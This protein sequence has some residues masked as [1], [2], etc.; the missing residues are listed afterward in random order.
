MLLVVTETA[1]FLTEDSY[2]GNITDPLTL[3][4]YNY[5]KSSPLNYIDPSGYSAGEVL[6]WGVATG[7][8]V[9][10][11]DGP[12]PGYADAAGVVILGGSVIVAGGI[13]IYDGITYI[14]NQISQAKSKEKTDDCKPEK[15][16]KKTE[17]GKLKEPT[18]PGKMQN[19]VKKGQAPKGVKRVDPADSNIPGSQPHIHFGENEAALNQDGTWHDAGKPHPK[20]N[21]K[22]SDW[23]I[24]NG[25]NL[26]QK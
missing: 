26:P 22:Q 8:F 7:G 18:S 14:G 13:V 2:L 23:I 19:Q 5:V 16:E 25:W 3:N 12:F 10:A 6:E 15:D 4:R 1:N 21:N 20:I 17:S 11:L 24:D 9:A